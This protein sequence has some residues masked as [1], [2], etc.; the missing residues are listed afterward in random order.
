[1]NFITKVYKRYSLIDLFILALKYIVGIPIHVLSYLFPRDKNKW[2]LGHQNGFVDNSK[3]FFIYLI[4]QTKSNAIWVAHTREQYSELKEKQLPVCYKYSLK[5]FYHLMTAYYYVTTS[6]PRNV[7]YWTSGGAYII[8]LWHGVGIKAIG[9][10]SASLGDNSLL[11]RILIPKENPSL[12]LSTS[13]F[14]TEHFSKS[15]GIEKDRIY[16]GIYPRCYF[17]LES[18][19]MQSDFIDKYESQYTKQFVKKIS[20]YTRV[21][22]YMPTWRLMYGDKLINVALPDLERLNEVLKEMNGLFIIKSHASVKT[23]IDNIDKYSNII[24]IIPETDIYPILPYTDVLI[25]DYSSIYYDYILMKDK[26]CIL[27]DFDYD[28]YVKR[29]YKFICDYESYTPGPHAKNFSDLIDI[30]KSN[31]PFDICNRDWITDLF[32]GDYGNKDI[33]SLYERILKDK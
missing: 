8:N 16:E 5:G 12:F 31:K 20:G 1:M 11:S 2:V 22:V 26:G 6:S 27:Y 32:W 33:K 23:K 17:L 9:D 19:K 28:D 25:T 4:S 30:L 10:S 29:E 21:F 3:Y 13:S 24:S 14:M 18:K 7:C 15:K